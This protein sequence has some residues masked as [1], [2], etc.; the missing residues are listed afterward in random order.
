MSPDKK[1]ASC[2]I[3]SGGLMHDASLIMLNFFIKLDLSKLKSIKM[4]NYMKR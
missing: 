2:Y 1:P 3:H 4:C